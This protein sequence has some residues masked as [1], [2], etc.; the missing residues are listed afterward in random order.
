MER[1]KW[2]DGYEGIYMISDFGRVKSFRKY[3]A[4]Y[5]LSNINK[6]GDYL[7]MNL[8]DS[9]GKRTTKGIHILVAAAFLGDIPK[10]WHVH[11]IDGNKQ[12]NAAR[13]L[14]IIHPKDHRAETVRVHPQINDG[15]RNYNKYVKTKAILQ[16]TLDDTLVKSYPNAKEAGMATGICSRNILMVASKTPFNTRGGVRKQAGGYIWKFAEESEV[17]PCEV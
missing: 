9:S 4:G 17:M 6:N 1:W 11:H 3:E 12:N 2:I 7:R 8:Y 13:N 10:G 5:I 15:I 16:Y 14:E